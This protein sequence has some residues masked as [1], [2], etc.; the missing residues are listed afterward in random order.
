MKILKFVNPPWETAGNIKFIGDDSEQRFSKHS[1]QYGT[2]WVW[3]NQ[4]VNYSLNS[5]GYRCAEFHDI[6]WGESIVIFGC[7]RV[8]GI[9]LDDSQTLGSRLS[10]KLSMPAVNMGIN[11]SS[12]SVAVCNLL[13]LLENYPP[14]RYV[15]N[16]WTSLNRLPFWNSQNAHHLGSWTSVTTRTPSMTH[17]FNLWN[18]NDEN[19]QQWA[20]IFRAASKEIL[21]ARGITHYEASMFQHTSDLFDIPF[22]D[23]QDLARDQQ[24]PGPKTMEFVA[25]QIANN[26]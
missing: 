18:Q 25:T 26:F 1:V 17:L 19:P 8:F 4:K 2:Q 9:G 11:G 15:V 6:D 3:K 13:C 24:H 20:K 7:S 10:E 23:Y 5:Q 14:P 22:F 16:L 21:N 12:I